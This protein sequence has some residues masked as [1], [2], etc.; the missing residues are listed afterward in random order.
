MEQ[1]QHQRPLPD[2]EVILTASLAGLLLHCL[3]ATGGR[4]RGGV[5]LGRRSATVVWVTMAVFPPQLVQTPVACSF[6][7]GCIEVLNAAKAGLDS[8]LTEQMGTIV[9]WVHSHPGIGPFLSSTDVSTFS[10]WRQLDPRAIAVVADPYLMGGVRDQIRWWPSP[11]RGHAIVLDQSEQEWPTIDQVAQVAKAIY[12]SA[13]RDTRWDI[14]ASGT[15][16]T[17]TV[18][19]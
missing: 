10:S 8:T 9:G 5:L 14:V 12:H 4:E 2:T 19:R 18:P 7:D 1:R 13:D 3:R 16:M 17:I 11:G 6:D 15:L